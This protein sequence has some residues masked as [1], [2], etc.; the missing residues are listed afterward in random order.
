MALEQVRPLIEEAGH[1]LSARLPAEP[2]LLDADPARLVQVLT[3]LLNN[4]VKYSPR[5]GQ[6]EISV[7]RENGELRINVKDSGIGIPAE[8]LESVFEM[9]GQLD[10]SLESGYKGLGI[11]LALS[12]TLV[13][14]HGGRIKAH[15]EGLG[16]G[17][18]FSVWLPFSAAAESVRVLGQTADHPAA[19]GGCRVLMVDDNRDV[20]TAMS[21]LMRILGH[22]VRV[23]YNGAQALE[24]AD[25][26]RPDVVLLDIAMPQMNG[27]E[28]ARALRS[29]PQ[30]RNMILVAV[31]GWGREHDQRRSAEAGFDRH[32]TKPVDPIA[33]ETFLDSITRRR[34]PAEDIVWQAVPETP[35]ASAGSAAFPP[36]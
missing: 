19:A 16:R 2:I 18:E 20:A 29:H 12:R 23:A 17:S 32:M 34:A 31:T 30:G 14:K 27:Y 1:A 24:L 15:S 6:I 11:G 7:E 3:N 28:V 13:A 8:K 36:G 4:A 9:F 21:R 33:L 10:R 25:S 22:D 5:G 26:F 35:P